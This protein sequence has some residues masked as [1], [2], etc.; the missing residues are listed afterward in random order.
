MKDTT[1]CLICDTAVPTGAR[2]GLT[3]TFRQETSAVK[4]CDECKE[5][6]EARDYL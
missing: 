2:H 5:V 6:A 3:L 1:Y 4:L